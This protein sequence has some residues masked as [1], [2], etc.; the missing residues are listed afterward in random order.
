MEDIDI[1]KKFDNAKLIDIVKI[2][3][4]MVMMTNFVTVL[5]AYWKKEAGVEKNYSNSVI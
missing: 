3:S 5:S 4:V 1:L 2:T